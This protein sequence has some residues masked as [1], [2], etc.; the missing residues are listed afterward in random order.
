MVGPGFGVQ[1]Q[2]PV[3]VPGFGGQKQLS[4]GADLRIGVQG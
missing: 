3:P 2:L 4:N 1:G